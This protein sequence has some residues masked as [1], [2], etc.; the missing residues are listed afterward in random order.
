[1]STLLGT[2]VIDPALRIAGLTKG[3]GII[4]DSDIRGE[5]IP[6]INRLLGSWNCDG[7]KIFSTKV[8]VFDLVAEQ[9]SYTIGPSGNF[10]TTRP[11]FI[12]DANFLF[13]SDPVVRNPIQIYDSHQWSLQ[14]LQEITG[15]PP[16]AL[17]YDARYDLSGG[18]GVIYIVGQAP[19]D[20]QLELY[21][22]QALKMDFSAVTD[23]VFF[24]PGY[25]E[26]LVTSLALKAAALS[27]DY[28]TINW[29][30]A[31]RE[32]QKAVQALKV[33]NTEC[34]PLYNEAAQISPRYGNSMFPYPWLLGPYQG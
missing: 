9:V 5:L 20:Y 29:A 2:G 6:A 10:N 11:L 32:A 28:T 25:E 21:T 24:P 1:M 7:H 13:P 4:P 31:R 19:V 26:A 16:W 17:W 3:P 23:V 12:K 22:W 15:A 30:E 18:L 27:P 8:E 34:P 14:S 33:L